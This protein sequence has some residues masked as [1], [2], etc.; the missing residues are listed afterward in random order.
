MYG[1]FVRKGEPVGIMF[2]LIVGLILWGIF[3]D[4]SSN[5]TK[6]NPP[7]RIVQPLSEEQFQKIA[8]DVKRAVEW[9]EECLI[10]FDRAKTLARWITVE[11]VDNLEQSRPDRALW[12]NISKHKVQSRFSAVEIDAARWA[13]T[14]LKQ[15]AKSANDELVKSELKVR[16]S[17]FDSIE[18]SPLTEEQARAV[19]CMDNRVHLIA[20]AG[21]GKTSVMVAR[22]AYAVD[23]GFVA[24][25]K[26]LLLAFNHDAAAELEERVSERFTEA[27][28]RWNNI[29][30]TTFHSFGLGLLGKAT[31]SKPRVAPWV[32]T[33]AQATKK[34]LEIVDRL[35]ESD[36][37]FKKKWD[38]YRLVFA[39]APLNPD[40]AAKDAY[41][42]MTG[43]VGYGTLDGKVVKS[44]GERMIADWLFLNNVNYE[45]ERE[46]VEK[47]STADYSQYHP[48]FF[49]PQID[50]WH[51]HWALD[52]N[53][54][55]PSE[56]KNYLEQKRWKIE[57][58]RS[59]GTTLIESTFDSIVNGNGLAVLEDELSRRGVSLKW[60]PNR[61]ANEQRYVPQDET[62]ARQV[63]RFM[64]HV[65][66]NGLTREDIDE[67]LRTNF[68]YLAGT[69]TATFLDVYWKIHQA[70][71]DE[72]REN[73]FVDFDDMLLLAAQCL[74]S[75]Q[76]DPGYEMVLVD[77]FQ[78]ASHARA[79]LI[80][81]LLAGKGRYLLAV[82]DDWQSI[83]AFAGSDLEVLSSFETW[84]GK[85]PQ[86]ALQKTFRCTQA[87]SDVASSFVQKNPNQF[88]KTVVSAS[89]E[90]GESPRVVFSDDPKA[91]VA[92]ILSE[93]SQLV[94]R[95]EIVSSKDGKVSVLVL[96]RYN[97][98][99]EDV[100]RTTPANL[101]VQFLTVHRS[102]GLEAD[103]VIV[104]RLLAG[105]MGFPSEIEDDPVL[106]L[107]MAKPDVYPDAEER[108]LLYV[109]ITRAR[110]LVI[111][112]SNKS[113]PSRFVSE[114]LDSGTVN[115]YD[116]E[117]NAVEKPIA[118]TK[119]G[120]GTMVKRKGPHGVFFGCSRFPSCN[121]SSKFL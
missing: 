93:I 61:K 73:N 16:K 36:S 39:S 85:G 26:I 99:A 45:Y 117:L 47:L 22:A 72:L 95:G 116:A 30:A 71:N 23:R 91:G 88:K 56:F 54:N 75:G 105:R 80:R 19:V 14:D 32:G 55:P 83:N 96:G 29:T 38:L 8:S 42:R 102:K 50:V 89:E 3:S 84:F 82:G 5:K 120:Q 53:G 48:D 104:S 10:A 11:Q 98:V 109:A 118:C 94:R 25:E 6:P 86:L 77:E 60:E 31:G 46:Y 121:Y 70:W 74:E 113:T 103:V 20:A 111:L 115:P 79:R 112:V 33:D 108:R 2:L 35:K 1:L 114:L 4:S 107:A 9:R 106:T 87:I 43:R 76:H 110:R 67:R 44:F 68:S 27:G 57:T 97:Y 101:D 64:G 24:P 69:R 15:Q 92:S 100:P 13:S 51:E 65:K 66:S 78:D 21:S 7:T 49:Y 41:D 119:C 17:F 52:R 28:L 59:F 40:G 90:K 63:R 18:R 62:F 58:H 81:G 34:T 37:D 12:Q